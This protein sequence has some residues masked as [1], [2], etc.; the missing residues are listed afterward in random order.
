MG[1][2]LD[3]PDNH[4][5]LVNIVVWFTLVLSVLA[6]S[7]RCVIKWL[8]QRRLHGDDALIT[9]STVC[10]PFF[11]GDEILTLSKVFSIGLTVSVS[12]E[13]ANGLGQHAS[14]L[15]DSELVSYQKVAAPR[16][17]LTFI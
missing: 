14:A 7:A 13:V 11:A 9:I 4:G 17:C 12:I 10:G 6:V 5:S 8:L 1:E 3:A 16:L 15:Q 2:S